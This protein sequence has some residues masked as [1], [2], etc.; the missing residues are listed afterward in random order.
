FGSI[1]FRSSNAEWRK[2]KL[3][4]LCNRFLGMVEY[5]STYEGT[6]E[7]MI[8]ELA[9]MDPRQIMRK[10]FQNTAL[11]DDWQEDIMTGVKLAHDLLTFTRLPIVT[12]SPAP[13]LLSLNRGP[14]IPMSRDNARWVRDTLTIRYSY[15]FLGNFRTIDHNG[16]TYTGMPLAAVRA[17]IREHN[18]SASDILDGNGLEVFE[19]MGNE[20]DMAIPSIAQSIAMNWNT[21]AFQAAP[22]TVEVT[23]PL[24]S[25]GFAESDE[26]EDDEFF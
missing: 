26:D 20:P 4:R 12:T 11:P 6:V 9:V 14:Y 5:A 25:L 21:P 7:E 8:N 1:E 19:S 3:V 23:D 16:R 2:G 24:E 15:S 10:G 13:T 18:V 22:Q 17:V